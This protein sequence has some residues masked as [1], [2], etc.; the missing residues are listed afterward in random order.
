MMAVGP[1]MSP[2]KN[3]STEPRTIG[4][5]ARF[6]SGLVGSKSFILTLSGFSAVNLSCADDKSSAMPNRPIAIG[7]NSRPCARSSEPNV[8][9]ETP[10]IGSM[11][12]VLKPNPRA[13]MTAALV[14]DELVILERINSPRIHKAKNSGGPKRRA[15]AANTGAKNAKPK[16]PMEPATKEPTAATNKAAPALPFRAI[17]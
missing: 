9:R 5:R 12:T 1:G 14:R 6:H 7:T 16:I 10:D 8:K 13:T 4:H 15:E 2:N 3:P 11:P 17:S